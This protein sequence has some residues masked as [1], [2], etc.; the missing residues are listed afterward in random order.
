MQYE[1]LTY[2]LPYSMNMTTDERLGEINRI[3]ESL[4]SSRRSLLE[5]KY[6][7][8]RM[9]HYR[10]NYSFTRL[11]SL[12]CGN[13]D[14][15]PGDADMIR[16]ICN[17][18]SSECLALKDSHCEQCESMIPEGRLLYLTTSPHKTFCRA[19]C[20]QKWL[21]EESVQCS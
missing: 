21:R 3:L 17:G 10:G 9:L 4:D 8:L 2:L 5:E 18:F 13:T 1:E 15:T 16:L 14:S 6:R 20:R 7:L 12:D 11:A 19:S